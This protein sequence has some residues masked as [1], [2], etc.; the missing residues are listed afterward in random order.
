MI[1]LVLYCLSVAQLRYVATEGYGFLMA[2]DSQWY[3]FVY[4][5]PAGCATTIS[6]SG[7]T[8]INAPA[9]STGLAARSLSFQ[10]IIGWEMA[11]EFVG[12]AGLAI[13]CAMLGVC[14]HMHVMWDVAAW[15]RT[16]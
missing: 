13:G 14:M 12:K 11:I 3:T 15:F 10:V 1:H 4:D 9:Y 5:D 8:L 16:G 2:Y 6:A 7:V